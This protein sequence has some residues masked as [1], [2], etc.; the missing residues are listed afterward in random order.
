MLLSENQIDNRIL[1]VIGNGFDLHCKLY[2]SFSHFMNAEVLV[3]NY[4][5]YKTYNIIFK[6]FNIWY[7]LLTFSFYIDDK[8]GF[9]TFINNNDPRWMDVENYIKGI[10]CD[11]KNKQYDWMNQVLYAVKNPLSV[12]DKGFYYYRDNGMKE[13][14]FNYM[15][16]EAKKYNYLTDFLYDELERFEDDFTSYLKQEAEKDEFVELTKKTLER[17]KINKNYDALYVWSFNYTNPVNNYDN[18]LYQNIHGCLEDENNRIIIGIDQNELNDEIISTRK[19]IIRFTKAWKKLRYI[20]P[21]NELPDRNKINQISIYGHS[22]GAQDYSYFHSIF[23]YYDIINK[24]NLKVAFYF[25][26]YEEN[27]DGTPNNEK[28][29]YN[30]LKYIDSIFKLLND[31]AKNSVNEKESKTLVTRLLLERRILIEEL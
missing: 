11:K 4:Q 30:Y 27:E 7:Y 9:F 17:F 8:E 20:G 13:L 18:C 22:L 26:N 1:V 25:S 2:S 12:R 16:R 14:I 23:N 28:N 10:L 19:G 31:Y 24:S 15:S 29:Q 5:I 6:K 21:V 3:E